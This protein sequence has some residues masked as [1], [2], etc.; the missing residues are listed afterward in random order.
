VGCPTDTFLPQVDGGTGDPKQSYDAD[1]NMTSVTLANSSLEVHGLVYPANELM[2]Y[3]PA[4]P[5]VLEGGVSPLG[6]VV[7]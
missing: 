7:W 1:D 4:D 3:S 2:T 5:G 6:P